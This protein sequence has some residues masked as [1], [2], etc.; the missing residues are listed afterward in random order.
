[1]IRQQNGKL[2]VVLNVPLNLQ[3]PLIDWL[4]AREDGTGFTSFSVFGHGTG[5]EDLSPAEQVGGR[6]RRQQFQIQ[7]D[8][9]GLDAF[10]DDARRT[11]GMA[12]VQFWVLP[13]IAAG[14]LTSE[15]G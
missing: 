2:L 8:E 7:I 13:L 12:G 1:M 6:Q 11:L 4:L 14:R 15:L 5:H 3:E 10:L 9:D